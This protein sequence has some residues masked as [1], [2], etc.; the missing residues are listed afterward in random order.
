MAASTSKGVTIDMVK[1]GATGTAIT[2]TAVTK[3]KPVVVTAANTLKDGD[4]VVFPQGATGLKEIDGKRFIVDSASGT[5]FELL[6]SDATGST[7]TFAA[8][9]KTPMGYAAADLVRMCWSSL[10]F[11][12]EAPQ[13]ISVGTFCDPS[14]QI[15]STVT[16]A[17]T[18]DFAGYVDIKAAD[19]IAMVEAEADGGAHE[20]RIALPN[21]GYIA[22]NASV[23][24]LTVDVPLEGAVAYSGSLTLMSKPVHLF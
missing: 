21:N 7:D 23:A 24:S 3:A 22:F 17:G 4:I 16:G 18:V 8:G 12:P 1:T 15:S 19:Y 10:G 20:F 14:A 5:D 6:G 9:A 2:V 13:T 11:N